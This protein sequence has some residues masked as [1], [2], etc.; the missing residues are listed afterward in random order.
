MRNIS[1][2]A[3]LAAAADSTEEVEIVLIKIT[4]EDLDDPVRL[5]TDPTEMI[6]EDPLVYGTHSTWKTG[7]GSPFLFVLVSALLP[8]DEDEGPQQAQLSLSNVDNDIAS[9]LRE[10]RTQATVDM[11]VVLSSSPN[12]VEVEFLGLKLVSA[13]GDASSITLTISREPITS[14]PWPS[15]RMTRERF[16]SLFR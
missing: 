15:G 1:L 10:V 11:S 3:R 16:P 8:G 4:H 13:S 6:T 2:N 12:T 7:D 9:L 5:S 14:E